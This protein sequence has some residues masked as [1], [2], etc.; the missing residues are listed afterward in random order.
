MAISSIG[1]GSG[2]PLD[3]LLEDMR[4]VENQPLVLIKQRQVI[5]EARL[6]GYGIIKGS[7]TDLQKAAQALNKAETYGAIK[8]T[9]NND[10]ITLKSDNT[11]IAGNYNVKIN[12][13]ATQQSL[14]ALGQESR[15][16]NFGTGGSLAITLENGE[17]HSIELGDDT[18]LQGVMKAINANPDL[19]VQATMV[20]DGS[21]SPYR[22]MITAKDSGTEAAV[23]NITITDNQALQDILGFDAADIN[24]GA[25]A[26]YKVDAAQNAQININGIDITSQSNTIENAIEGVTITLNSKPTDE[27]VIKLNLARDDSVAIKAVND[28]VKAYNGLL[29]TIGNQT[30]FDVDAETSSALTGDSLIRRVESQ[31]RA[32]LN[33]TAGVGAIHNLSSMGI[34]TDYKTGKLEVNNEKLAEAVKNNLSDV[35]EFLSG[36]NGLGTIVD[37]AANEFIKSGGYISN[38]TDSIDESIKQLKKQYQATSDR[39]DTKMENYRKQFTQLDVLVN[40][41]NGI[42]SY[43]T[44]QLS[45]LGNMNERK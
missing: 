33:G 13:L 35:T 37:K 30:K 16:T 34:T 22:L 43:L 41:M 38:A 44:Q 23:S 1:V 3:K 2:L 10:A 21:D 42:S 14:V 29:D 28:F 5:S 19:G 18:S 25:T 45:M 4:K 31:M 6:S 24:D 20:N 17:S 39:I 9:S 32:A 11:A 12:A 26:K 27:T 40:Q 8:G 15:D 7:L 36:K